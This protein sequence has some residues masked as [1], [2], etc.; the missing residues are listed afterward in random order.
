[1]RGWEGKLK[2]KATKVTFAKDAKFDGHS[3]RKAQKQPRGKSQ[4][5]GGEQHLADSAQQ[6]AMQDFLGED[7]E[8]R[9][10]GRV[11]RLSDEV[12]RSGTG[13]DSGEE[14]VEALSEMLRVD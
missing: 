11:C 7:A 10:F 9:A 13:E 6:Q 1:M 8:V 5:L 4:S 3:D 12:A 14:W 2:G